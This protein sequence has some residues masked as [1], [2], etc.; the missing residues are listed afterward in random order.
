MPIYSDPDEGPSQA[1]SRF[2]LGPNRPL[3]SIVGGGRVGD[4]ILWRNKRLSATILGGFT[5]IW[6]L[7]EVVELHFITMACYLLMASML[8]LFAWT[9]ASDFFRWR[10]PSVYEIQVSETTAR[11]ILS[12]LNKFLARFYKLSCGH[13]LA[14]FFMA[15]AVLW[16]L[17]IIGSYSSALNVIY[18]VFLFVITIPVLYER[19]EREVNYIATQG[20]GDMKR[21]YKK[22]DANLLSK[23]PRGPVKE[24]KYK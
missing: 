4:V 12:R 15:L 2:W 22:L 9:Q 14:R 1:A 18:V 3:H 8:I 11:H 6:F 17:S 21:L 7:F 10:P 24:R 13:D 20:K 19:Y 23:I 16:V 5:M